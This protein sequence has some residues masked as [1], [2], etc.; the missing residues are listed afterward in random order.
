MKKHLI[1]LLLMALPLS[2]TNKSEKAEKA[3]RA[4]NTQ[5]AE[6]SP[7][8][9]LGKHLY[10]DKRLSKDNT[11]SCNTCHNI[12][13]KSGGVD[14]LPTSKGIG[15]QFGGRNAPTVWNAKFLSVQFWDGRAKDL[16]EQAKGPITNP[17][18][19]GMPTH[20]LAITKIKDVKG[21]QDLFKAAFPNQEKPMTI[22]NLATA[23]AKFEETLVT[24]NSPFDKFKAGD[25]SSMSE[26]AQEG[27][28]KFQSVGCV[29]CHSGDHFAGPNLPVGTGFYMKFPTIPGSEYDKKYDLLSDTGRYEVTKNEADKHMWR[30]PT[31]RNVA[32]TGPYFHNGKV[33]D[34][35][36]AVRVMAKTQLN[37][38]LSDND[39]KALVAFLEALT[40]DLP[41]IK[42]PQPL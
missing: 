20:D 6:V 30:V 35:P 12:T 9:T 15:N 32:L 14:G 37:K 28:E 34:L 25:K 29:S 42:E 26:L 5:A 40:G 16:A 41:Q 23:I 38:D 10:F 2:C 18:E 17:I 36:E 13:N 33:E 7:V 24:T 11:I 8:V 4:A 19:M 21:Y 31:L 1:I 3:E 27:Y 22:D 39:V